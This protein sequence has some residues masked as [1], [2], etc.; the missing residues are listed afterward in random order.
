M[1]SRSASTAPKCRSVRADPAV[2][3]GVS[4]VQMPDRSPMSAL[5]YAAVVVPVALWAWSD[6]RR[7]G[8]PNE[9]LWLAGAVLVF[10]PL[11][12]AAW[13]GRRMAAKRTLK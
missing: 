12:I 7:L 5:L 2:C 1:R 10:A 4:G 8:R 13:I 9:G 11:G 3:A 6:M